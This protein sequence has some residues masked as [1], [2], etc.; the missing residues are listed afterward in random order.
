MMSHL[1]AKR[2]TR[3]RA[4]P[5]LASAAI[6]ITFARVTVGFCPR[7]GNSFTAGSTACRAST[8]EC[9]M[10]QVGALQKRTATSP[11]TTTIMGI[12]LAPSRTKAEKKSEHFKLSESGMVEFGSSQRLEASIPGASQASLKE[13][14]A[15]PSRIVYACWDHDL[16]TPLGDGV[17]RMSFKG[18]SF[19]TVS[20]DMSVEIKLWLA[21]NGNIK[22][23]SVG[24]SLDEMAKILGQD[25]VDTFYL[26]LEGELRVEETETKVRAL[27]LK[28]TLL[29]GDVGVNIGGKMPRLLSATPEQLVKRAALSVNNRVL[30]YVS[31]TFVGT[32]AGDY[33]QW[34]RDAND[35]PAP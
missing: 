35:K 12:S 4:A 20:I 28:S 16:V 25:F 9:G 22:C 27:T 31:S 32:V 10:I 17:F 34:A 30:E 8:S 3:R 1:R 13:Y 19:L 26:E 6:L 14:I 29:S 2:R 15:D 11:G 24:Y 23:K 5:A 18:Q 33:R 21:P 7:V